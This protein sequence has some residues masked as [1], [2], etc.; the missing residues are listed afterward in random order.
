MGLA[1]LFSSP[2]PPPP[3]E[4]STTRSATVRSILAS[5]CHV[6]SQR[7]SANS[8]LTYL[9]RAG[10]S[11]IEPRCAAPAHA[12]LLSCFHRLQSIDRVSYAQRPRQL[13]LRSARED[14]TTCS[15]ISQWPS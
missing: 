10:V 11:S 15:P 3:L 7:N 4:R 14:T 13:L 12:R 8:D 6:R 1:P 5:A 2:S 9:P